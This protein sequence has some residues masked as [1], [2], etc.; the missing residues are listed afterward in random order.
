MK[1]DLIVQIFEGVNMKY[2]LTIFLILT[3]VSSNVYADSM[4]GIF[5]SVRERNKKEMENVRVSKRGDKPREHRIDPYRVERKS[6]EDSYYATCKN[7]KFKSFYDQVDCTKAA[8][9]KYRSDFPDRGTEAYGEKF[10]SKL[11]KEEGKEKR[12]QLLE[13]LDWVSYYPKQENKE[14]ELTVDHLR[15]E[16]FYIERYVMKI[17]PREYETR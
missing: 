6:K 2:L 4:K 10:Y 14:T 11:S 17:N 12:S 3:G 15:N 5:D 13:L 9:E 8:G 7:T 16:I 1:T